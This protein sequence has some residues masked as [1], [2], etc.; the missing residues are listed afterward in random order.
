M[1]SFFFY[2]KFI[3]GGKGNMVNQNIIEIIL[4]AR[5]EASKAAKQAEESL[6]HA[7]DTATKSWNQ[8]TEATRRM[9]NA[10][11]QLGQ[12]ARNVGQKVSSILDPLT[13]KL[14]SLQQKAKD[15]GNAFLEAHPKIKNT[16]ET[17]K[18]SLDAAMEHVKSGLRKVANDTGLTTLATKAS[19]SFQNMSKTVSSTINKV[20][21]EVK[22]LSL[23][24]PSI[25][26]HGNDAQF[27][28]TRMHVL[29]ALQ[30]L[31]R[32]DVDLPI[33]NID[34]MATAI[35]T[36][37]SGFQRVHNTAT[38]FR[39]SLSSGLTNLK[40]KVG[41]FSNSIV[42]SCSEMKKLS[43]EAGGLGQG[44]TL[45]KGAL[46]NVVGMVGYDLVNS[47]V[48]GVRATIN[49]RGNIESFSQRLGMSGTEVN[50]F[51]KDLDQLQQE[52]KKVD[53]QSVGAT[54]L[55]LANKLGI[56][57]DK[58]GE[59]AR[60]TAVMSSAFIREGRTSEDAIL[61]VSDALDG[62]FGR[63]KEIGITQDMLKNNGWN[64]NLEDTENLME[65]I[66]KTMDE[67]GITETAKQVT[68]LD[69]AWQVLNVSM[70]HLLTEVIIPFVPIIVGLIEAFADAANVVSSFVKNLPDGAKI[71]LVAAALAV[72]AAVI[73]GSVQPALEA[74]IIDL[75]I[76][77]STLL[78]LIVPFLELAAVAA[79]VAIV[80]YELGKAMGWWTDYGSAMQVVGNALRACFDAIV[81][82]LQTVYNGFME[83]ANPVIQQFWN[84]LIEVVKPLQKHFQELWD[85][86]VK[87][88]DA[89]GGASGSGSFFAT[90]GRL[91][92]FI[93]QQLMVNIRVFV[94]VLVPLVG[95]IISI[96]TSL[97]DFV[98]QLKEAFDLLMQGDILGF[99]VQLGEAIG[100]LILNIV[101][102]LG[103]MFMEILLNFDNI[104]GGLLTSLWNWIIL[105]VQNAATG[106][107][108]M[109]MS[110]INWIAQLPG[111]MWLWL[112]DAI[113]K[114]QAW[115]WDIVEKAKQ[116]GSDAV[117]GFIQWLSTLPGKAW[118]WLLN[119]IAK[120]LGFGDKGKEEMKKAAREMV[121]GFTDWIKKLP[122]RMWDEL[123]NIGTQ[124]QNAVGPL[125]SKIIGLGQSLLNNFLGALG[126]HSPGFMSKNMGKEMQY[127]TTA[128]TDN[129][130][131]L[132]EAATSA[133]ESI[134][135]GYNSNDFSSLHVTPTVDMGQAENVSVPD[136]G[137]QVAIDPSLVATDNQMIADST[138][139]MQEQVS[140][141]L[142]QLQTNISTLGLASTN[143][144]NLLLANNLAV[145]QSYN[146]LAYNIQ[147][148]LLQ[149]QTSTTQQWNNVRVTTENNL[150]SILNS[151]NNVTKQMI[152]AW[153]TMKNSIVKA[154]D[155]IKTE[156]TNR[157]ERL[158]ST[159][160]TFYHNIQH[161]GGAGPNSIRTSGRNKP[162]GAGFRNVGSAL[163]TGLTT[164]QN[165]KKHLTSLDLSHM[166]LT[167]QQY[168]YIVPG[169]YNPSTNIRTDDV[170]KFL[171]RGGAGWNDVVSPN[172][173]YIKDTSN[174]WSVAG[175]VI[176]GKYPTG[177][178]IFKVKD[179]EN[180]SPTISYD[181]FRRMAEAVFNQCH[182]LF[183]MDSDMYG[184][185][186]AAAYN[187]NMNCSDST[188]FLIALAHACGLPASKIHGHWNNIGHFWADVAGHK[189]DT[190]GWMLHKT[191][192][193]SQSHAGSGP[194]KIEDDTPAILLILDRILERLG[195]KE[196][197]QAGVEHYGNITLTIEHIIN[198]ELPQGMSKEEVVDLLGE[199]ITDREILK[200]IASSRDF[201]ELDNRYKNRNAN[202]LARFS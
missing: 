148:T 102:G 143:N 63:L 45:L 164:V 94:A 117:N 87:L 89:F 147:Q 104:M 33:G 72:L 105:L 123:M 68:N 188:D 88:G 49:A 80:I 195:N 182:Y 73:W 9:E 166:G 199:K 115:A 84:E 27:Q 52:F 138:G 28:S 3:G 71:G 113:A 121:A 15:L 19:K 107:Y 173:K 36:I 176:L 141:Q 12:T 150:K 136:I 42:K 185:W 5:D 145:T 76:G 194:Y 151:T 95:Y 18:N 98:T 191:W 155:N 110:F 47:M 91:L 178:N 75:L 93:F 140:L 130:G 111:M 137:M 126:I 31:S 118:E 179:F 99:F 146:T 23:I 70:S 181:T 193:P 67:L 10:V 200:A 106:A 168:E 100:T 2:Q 180:G 119:T 64:G 157:F 56:T 85:S 169:G 192:T 79:A 201:Q 129:L 24:K 132:R 39:T 165:S 163:R 50:K 116:A 20:K 66:N 131:N 77:E 41:E 83:V 198:G 61:A 172:N 124:I 114:E 44:F 78:P 177:L 7:G 112:L 189:M 196:E 183:Y 26:I 142:L 51:N 101:T 62:Q 109:V 162:S 190:T 128:I 135:E 149:I 30:E 82:C 103:Q 139:A 167:N 86:L 38:T 144:M 65:A 55:E 197:K 175:P 37:N 125:V 96:I 57:G 122:Q 153:N 187:G 60:M 127:I 161:P 160:K 8:G 34:Q 21:T 59:L 4:R 159:I 174:K 158:W 32:M 97:I 48:Q 58:A 6:K 184:S 154:A 13:S 11:N 108:N 170:M 22:A 171:D 40:M 156:S 35:G 120:I 53:M 54:A 46:A 152:D 1:R 90:V 16:A 134:L 133:G 202:R 186:Q 43:S 25:M 81:A 14:G 17:I 29:T 92:G 69:D 74:L